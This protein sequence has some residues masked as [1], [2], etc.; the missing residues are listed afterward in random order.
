MYE[1]TV[2]RNS[3]IKAQTLK[4]ILEVQKLLEVKGGILSFSDAY[5]L[6]VGYKEH[7]PDKRK[8]RKHLLDQE[9]GLPIHIIQI[10][11]HNIANLLLV[12]KDAGISVQNLTKSIVEVTNNKEAHS[13]TKLDVSLFKAIKATMDSEWDKKCINAVVMTGMSHSEIRG[14]GFDPHFVKVQIN[15]ILNVVEEFGNA[16]LAADDIFNLRTKQ[17]IEKL[18]REVNRLQAIITSRRQELSERWKEEYKAKI[19][20]A[21]QRIANLKLVLTPIATEDN[22]R[23]KKSVKRIQKNLMEENRIK[24]RSLGAGAPKKISQE[25]ETW[26]SKQ[27]EEQGKIDG[28]RKEGTLYLGNRIKQRDML[29]IMNWKLKEQGKSLIKSATT[30]LSTSKKQKNK[31]GVKSYWSVAFLFKSPTKNREIF[32]NTY[33]PPTESSET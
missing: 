12:W 2:K 25:D 13:T 9:H 22:K 27:I 18:E 5:E 32:K 11:S 26:F 1:E 8:F 33:L 29:K 31:A 6:Y 20:V 16:A 4:G 10:C 3:K 30:I 17:K 24:S 23:R 15:K 14:Y 21:T 7:N 19:R 28:R